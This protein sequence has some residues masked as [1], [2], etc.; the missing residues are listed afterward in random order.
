VQ[1]IVLCL[2]GLLFSLSTYGHEIESITQHV[3]V[4]KH[5]E[6]G[7][8]QDLIGRLNVNRK[9]DV[10]FQGTYMERFDLY[11]KRLGGFV[12]LRPSDRWT[13]EAR[14]LQGKGNDIL[15]EKDVTLSAFHSLT[16]GISPFIYYRD[17]WFSLTHLYMGSLG[18][19]IE[20]VRHFVF[21]PMVSLGKA[22]FHDPNETKDVYTAGLKVIYYQEKD[23]SISVFG[24][25]G[26]EASQAIVGRS[27]ELIDTLTGG[28]SFG[29]YFSDHWRG[30]LIFDHTDYD[31]LKTEFHTTTLNLSRMF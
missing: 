28:A 1:W 16:E 20:K 21:I 3:N 9:F 4:R 15:P 13:F 29:Y 27:A 7:W 12:T 5:D 25:K 2:S 23:Y 11:E 6:I 17:S 10:G 26:K 8:Q 24:F 14:Y 31:E 30:Q 22:S 18:V 19:E